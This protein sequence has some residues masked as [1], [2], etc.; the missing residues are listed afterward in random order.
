MIWKNIRIEKI[1]IQT[2]HLEHVQELHNKNFCDE[3][4]LHSKMY[5]QSV[6]H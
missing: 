4:H 1:I 3:V 6:P 2:W 5:I